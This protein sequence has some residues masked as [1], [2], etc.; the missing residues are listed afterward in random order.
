MQRDHGRRRNSFEQVGV[1]ASQDPCRAHSQGER[2][3]EGPETEADDEQQ[4]P[5]EVGDGAE[6]TEE[7]A[8]GEARRSQSRAQRSEPLRGDERAPPE[9]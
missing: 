6:E 5:D 9:E 7:G 8:R 3:R 1:H 2:S 4:R